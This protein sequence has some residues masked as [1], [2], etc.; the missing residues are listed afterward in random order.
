MIAGLAIFIIIMSLVWLLFSDSIIQ[1][2][3]NYFDNL[4]LQAHRKLHPPKCSDCK[5]VD[6]YYNSQGTAVPEFD[7]CK[8]PKSIYSYAETE[9]SSLSSSCGVYGKLFEEKT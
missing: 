3:Q 5:W 7:H 9:R 8:S 2:W 1:L 6:A 4:K